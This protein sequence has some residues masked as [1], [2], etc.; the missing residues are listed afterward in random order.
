MSPVSVMYGA[1][2]VNVHGY[3]VQCVTRSLNTFTAIPGYTY[4]FVGS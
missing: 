2:Y 4:G 1:V 3:R